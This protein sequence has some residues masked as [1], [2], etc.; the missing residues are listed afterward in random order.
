MFSDEKFASDGESWLFV[1]SPRIIQPNVLLTLSFRSAGLTTQSHPTLQA[2]KMSGAR[3]ALITVQ[4][5]ASVKFPDRMFESNTTNALATVE[6]LVFQ[7]S[8]DT[9]QVIWT[10]TVKGTFITPRE[11]DHRDM[12]AGLFDHALASS[13]RQMLF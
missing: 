7:V 12:M 11:A 5:E 3:T 6:R 2:A 1:P 4:K 9:F 13:S 8:L 10:D